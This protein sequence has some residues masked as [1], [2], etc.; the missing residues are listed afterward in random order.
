VVPTD[1]LEQLKNR[2]PLLPSWQT[3]D[4]L[5]KVSAAWMIQNCG[6]KGYCQNDA[7]VS[8]HHALVIINQG[9]AGG[10]DIWQLACQVRETVYETFGIRLQVEPRVYAFN[11]PS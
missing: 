11:D 2:F 7:C 3:Q 1:E 9:N 4:D 10:E 8:D 5:V 6:L